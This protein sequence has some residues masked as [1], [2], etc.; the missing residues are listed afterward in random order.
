MGGG[1]GAGNNPG[2][3]NNPKLHK[4]VDVINMHELSEM[5][6]G[7]KVDKYFMVTAI[8]LSLSTWK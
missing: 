4:A 1:G 7:K 8:G 3:P 6:L 5:P 2:K